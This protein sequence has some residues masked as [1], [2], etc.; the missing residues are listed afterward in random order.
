MMFFNR[1]AGIGLAAFAMVL[2]LSACGAHSVGSN[3]DSAIDDPVSPTPESTIQYNSISGREGIDG[4]V[5]AVK[6]DDTRQAHPQIGLDKADV[7]YIEQ[8]EAGLTRLLAIFSSEIP[9]RVGPVRSARISDMDL[10]AQYG[11]V[12][13]TYSGAQSKLRPIIRSANL[14]DLG[15]EH[16]SARIYPRDLQRNSPVNLI[17][18]AQTLMEK[19]TSQ[20]LPVAIS[21]NMGWTFG[22][23]QGD[24]RAITAAQVF[25]PANSYTAKWSS[26]DNRWLLDHGAN[27]NLGE[28]GF[29]L[30]PTT[31]LIQQVSITPSSF[32]DKF[33]GVTPFSQS[34]GQGTGFVLRDGFVFAA[35]W[36]RPTEADGTSWTRADGTPITFARGQVW[37]ALTNTAPIFTLPYV[38]PEVDAAK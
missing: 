33:G 9:E 15:A 10:L 5:I 6:I 24:G 16:E 20:N 19:I 37:I 4:P 13:F 28:D 29:H 23:P 22:D 32:G 11:R 35:N 31:F 3:S 12:A 18:N 8:V 2:I 27:A 30:G 1:R 21:K 36:S 26:T 14:E 25:W 34:V 38:A 17:L 7:V